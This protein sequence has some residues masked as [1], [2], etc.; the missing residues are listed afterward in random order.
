MKQNKKLNNR[1][2][3]QLIRK[4]RRQLAAALR[5]GDDFEELHSQII[6]LLVEL[7]RQKK[8]FQDVIEY[9]SDLHITLEVMDRDPNG[10]LIEIEDSEISTGTNIREN[11]GKRLD[12]ILAQL[13]AEYTH[14][15]ALYKP[16]KDITNK[17]LQDIKAVLL[18]IRDEL[19]NIRA[20][21]PD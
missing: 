21:L 13:E 20:K 2:A 9:K 15:V 10:E 19:K 12:E 5:D 18:D 3:L 8:G 17:E 14:K 4:Y 7:C 6:L 16:Q 11:F 1:K